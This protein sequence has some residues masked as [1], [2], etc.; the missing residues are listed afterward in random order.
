MILS[1]KDAN[2]LTRDLIARLQGML[3]VAEAGK[4]GLLM[5]DDIIKLIDCGVAGFDM[6]DDKLRRLIEELH[7]EQ[8]QHE[9]N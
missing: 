9:R 8:H 1:T 3:A 6:L 7:A 5:T 4:R 2:M